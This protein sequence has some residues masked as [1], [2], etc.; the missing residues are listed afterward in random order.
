M[1]SPHSACAPGEE[2]ERRTALLPKEQ[3][4]MRFGK[5]G[6]SDNIEDRRGGGG[7][8]F[9]RGGF[10]RGGGPFRVPMGGRR[11]GGFG[12]GTIIIILIVMFLFGINPLDILNGNF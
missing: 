4:Q 11:G 9:P 10:G 1:T 8:G 7:F 5:G 2:R 3:R 12:I 6:P